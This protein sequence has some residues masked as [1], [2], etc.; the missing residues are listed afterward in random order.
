[1]IKFNF[2]ETLMYLLYPPKCP[3]CNK[4]I[5]KT[6]PACPGC[7]DQ[8]PE[9]GYYVKI[10]E[11]SGGKSIYCVAPLQYKDKANEPIWRFKF[12]G[13]KGYA[14]PFAIIMAKEVSEQFPGSNFDLITSVPLSR[15]RKFERGYNQ[16]ELLGKRISDIL[17]IP[18]KNTLVKV[19]KNLPQHTLSAKKRAE[20]IKGVYSYKNHAII[21]GKS[22]LLCDDIVTTGYTLKECC[23]VLL[24]AGAKD[25]TCVTIAKS[26]L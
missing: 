19:K 13:Y 26:G 17:R 16:A 18:Y 14:V 24:K 11:K 15:T 22:I 21:K 20:N 12:R 10:L 7:K 4:I 6:E 23:S 9:H 3:Y 5:P 1:M 2:F 8:L 25:V